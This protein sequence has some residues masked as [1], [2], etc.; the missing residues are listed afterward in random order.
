M[1]RSRRS[2]RGAEKSRDAIL[3]T[4]SGKL[5]FVS[6][7]LGDYDIWRLDLPEFKLNQLTMSDAWN[8]NPRWSPDGKWVL[9]TSN[10]TEVPEVYLMDEWGNQRRQLTD[11]GKYHRTPVWAPDGRSYVC[12]TNYDGNFDLWLM[13]ISGARAPQQ[14]TDS[15]PS[16][17]SP[18]VSPDGERIVFTSERGGSDD[19]WTLEIA[20]GALT[21]LTDHEARDYSPRY[22][23]DGRRITFVTERHRRGLDPNV[24]LYLMNDDG[25]SVRRLTSN[26]GIDR[27][28]TWSPDGRYWIYTASRPRRIYE[29]L[30][31]MEVAEGIPVQLSIDREPLEREISAIPDAT[32]LFTLLPQSVIRKFYPEE[33]FGTERCPD[34]TL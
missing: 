14:L 18:D 10:R 25:T 30:M 23:P 9:Y 29:R 4:L 1:F 8:D 12:V 17:Y 32:G 33:Y 3:Q 13:D 7:K 34:W 5:V 11:T 28:C 20:S 19:I 22:S 24:D 27:Y 16:D 21:R 2:R 31:L 26:A 15:E 6:G